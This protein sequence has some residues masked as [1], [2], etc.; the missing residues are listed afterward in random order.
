MIY[1]LIFS[2]ANN[3]QIL[4]SLPIY[5]IGS[6]QFR[7][8]NWIYFVLAAYVLKQKCT[9]NQFLIKSEHISLNYYFIIINQNSKHCITNYLKYFLV[10]KKLQ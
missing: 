10:F 4:T 2:H 9:V 6:N 1:L 3:E 7:C 8:I 5:F